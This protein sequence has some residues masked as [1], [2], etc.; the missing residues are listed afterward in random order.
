MQGKVFIKGD[1]E[2]REVSTPMGAHVTIV[3]RDKKVM[4][5]LMPGQKS[6]ME[7]PLDQKALTK[8]LDV[9]QEGVTK[10]LL[11]TETLNG[12]EAEKYEYTTAKA[13]GRERKSII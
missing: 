2:R 4:W 10:K 7:M 3:R 12:Y 1:K 13:D 9:P 6:Y 11:G 8:V 5:N